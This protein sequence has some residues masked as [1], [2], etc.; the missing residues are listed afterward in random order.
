MFEHVPP[1]HIWPLVS[2]LLSESSRG[3]RIK[4]AALLAT[5]PTASQPSGDRER[6]ERAAAEFIAVQRLNDD[7]PEARTTLGN[8]YARRGLTTD[9]EAEYRA[10]LR[11]APQFSA[12]AINLADLYRELRR[13]EDGENVLRSA[14]SRV[15]P[16]GL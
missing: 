15:P 8:F 10:A 13:D 3:V 7:R 12:A 1:S 16:V 14:I 6:F 2:P 5:V 9:A 11:L 4:A